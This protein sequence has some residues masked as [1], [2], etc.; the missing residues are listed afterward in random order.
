MKDPL[1]QSYRNIAL[2]SEAFI[3]SITYASGGRHQK[4]DFG[5][6]CRICKYVNMQEQPKHLDNFICH[7]NNVCRINLYER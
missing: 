2:G 7:L 1:Q 4:E 6:W 3:K 5:N